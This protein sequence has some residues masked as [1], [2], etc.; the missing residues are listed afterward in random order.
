MPI[1]TMRYQSVDVLRGI[2]I[3]LMFTYHFSYDLHV[4]GYAV[5]H[6]NTH[7]FWL[8]YRALIVS[9]FLCLVGVGLYLGTRSG[10]RTQ[11]FLRRLG[12]LVVYA[13]LVSIGSYVMFPQSFIFFGILHFVA[14]ASV[15][16]LLFIR[17]YWSNLVLGTGVLLLGMFYTNPF[18]NAP[19]LNWIG[20]VTRKPLTEDFVPLFP[21]F[22]VVLIGLF[23]GRYFFTE[24]P[25]RWL[26]DWHSERPLPRLLGL[27]GR[28]SIH[29]YMLH[30]PIFMGALTLFGWLIP[31]TA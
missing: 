31:P 26:R 21:W 20:L 6:F 30:Q 7:P 9:L 29:I 25:L 12:L 14:L 5:F 18:F 11:S 19:G 23:L 3:V 2:A 16:G 27:A 22:G 10:I 28:Y 8:S 1:T 24:H 13:G 4:F 17:L 15:L